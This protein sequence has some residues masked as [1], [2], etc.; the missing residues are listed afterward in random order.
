[1]KYQS[2]CTPSEAPQKP[3][4]AHKYHKI[5]SKYDKMVQNLHIARHKQAHFY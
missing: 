5:S 4:Y 1:M 3:I 2:K